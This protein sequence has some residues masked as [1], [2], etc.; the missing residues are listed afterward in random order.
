VAVYCEELDVWEFKM[1]GAVRTEGR[2]SLN[3]KAF[4]GCLVRAYA[5]FI[6]ADGKLITQSTHAGSLK[7]V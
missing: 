7:V 2:W 6:S 5:G 4:Q 1:N 3:V